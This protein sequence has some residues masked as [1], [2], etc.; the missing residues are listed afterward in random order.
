ML[1]NEE[2]WIGKVGTWMVVR[3]W[4]WLIFRRIRRMQIDCGLWARSLLRRDLI[5][6]EWRCEEFC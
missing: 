4:I 5:L 1:M 2:Y 3:L 6:F